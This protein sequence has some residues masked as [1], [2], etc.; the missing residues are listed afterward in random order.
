MKAFKSLRARIAALIWLSILP[1]ILL[2]I[3]LGIEQRALAVQNI[4][5]QN[6]VL[7]RQARMVIS[8]KI[9]ST[10]TLM[11]ALA[12]SELAET[13]NAVACGN[14]LAQVLAH[15]DGY[16]SFGV[17]HL[18]GDLWC[19]ALPFT[20]TVNSAQ[21]EF[22]KN[23][24]RNN[25]FSLGGYQIGAVTGKPAFTFSIPIKDKQQKTQGVMIAGVNLDALNAKIDSL[26][27]PEGYAVDV[28]DEKGVFIVRWPQPR[29]YIGKQYADAPITNYVL[30]NAVNGGEYTHEM[31]WVDGVTRL[32]AFSQ[33]PVSN[34]RLFIRVGIAPEIALKPINDRVMRNVLGLIGCATIAVLSGWIL[35]NALIA[36]KT[37]SLVKTA[38][39]LSKGDL[40]ARTEVSHEEGELGQ[41]AGAFDEMAG[42][43]EQRARERDAALKKLSATNDA[44]LLLADVST[45]SVKSTNYD[46]SLQDIVNTLCQA[47]SCMAAI[48]VAQPDGALKPMASCHRN[49]SKL[50]LFEQ[51][52]RE[53]FPALNLN[54]DNA[55]TANLKAGKTMLY[56]THSDAFSADASH[57][58]MWKDYLMGS[59]LVVPLIQRGRVLGMLTVIR[60]EENEVFS[61]EEIALA[62]EFSARIAVALDSI[63]L[64]QELQTINAG[65]EQQVGKRTQQLVNTVNRLRQS[66]QELRQLASRQNE[67][68]E[69]ERTRI[70]REVHDQIGQALTSIKMDLSAALRRVDPAQKPV[71]EKLTSASQIADETIQVA[72]RIA[73]DL[74]P[75]ALDNLGLEAAAEG[76]LR[77]FERRSGIK[78]EL[79]SAVDEA[80]LP[81]GTPIVVFRI[82]QEALTNIAR[83]A[84][85][86][87]VHITLETGDDNLTLCVQ[88]NGIGITADAETQA[89]ARGSLGVTGMRERAMQLGGSLTLE[90]DAGHGT[91]LTLTLPLVHDVTQMSA[92]P[93]EGTD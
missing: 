9:E 83:H 43:I 78:C 93:D 69:A 12:Q 22:F 30:T 59:V 73:S 46:A 68:V 67:A 76:L 35:G 4:Q 57:E 87:A 61:Q 36:R 26:K 45:A 10:H 19:N 90:P 62:E 91:K 11:E 72:R 5:N 37:E 65:L 3:V 16:T 88:D 25:E 74:R 40:S 34:G 77:D 41:L 8:D 71:I 58:Q 75:G 1:G 51:A 32:F 13:D 18:D 85:A 54:T 28:I 48:F 80:S 82:L 50:K 6:L 56:R 42:Q 29:D 7:L 15:S 55:H 89:R 86:S 21:R 20:G 33:I 66:Q 70:A 60:E 44:H 63:R 27:W 49:P 84:K 53:S 23:A 31:P 79:D 47:Y 14:F 92:A 81:T 38:Q 39:R 64:Y 24:L 2:V 17:Y 52:V